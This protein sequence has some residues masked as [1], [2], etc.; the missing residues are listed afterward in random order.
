MQNPCL[1]VLIIHYVETG[2]EKGKQST[3]GASNR[4]SSWDKW[5][6]KEKRI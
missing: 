4:I 3:S 1:W 6:R 5:T 2:G